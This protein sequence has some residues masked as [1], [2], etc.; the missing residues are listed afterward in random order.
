MSWLLVYLPAAVMCKYGDVLPLIQIAYVG[1][2]PTIFCNS[3]TAPKW[4]KDGIR[5][6]VK[7][8]PFQVALRDVQDNESGKYACWGTLGEGLGNFTSYST[9]IVGST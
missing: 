4:F 1:T 3:S 8:N 2:T 7:G 6:G 9:L 5:M